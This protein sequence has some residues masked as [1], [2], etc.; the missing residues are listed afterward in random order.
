MTE[1]SMDVP[2]EKINMP[3]NAMNE[4][5]KESIKQHF[6]IDVDN[7][8]LS[9]IVDYAF[10]RIFTADEERSKVALIDFINSVLEF[11]ESEQIMELTVV[12]AN[13]P[14][15][16]LNQK[17]S[18]FDIR[19]KFNNGEQAIIE[20]QISGESDFKKRSQFIISKAYT[21]QPIAGLDYNALKKCYLICLTNFVL[22]KDKTEFVNDYMY[23]D[24]AGNNL[25]DDTTIMFIELPKIDRIL[26]K[27]VSEMTNLEMWTIFFRYVTDKSKRKMLN[28]IINR[29]DGIKMAT[30]VLNEISRDE[31][32]RAQYESELIYAMDVQSGMNRSRREGLEEGKLTERIEIAKKMLNRGVSVNII[33]EDTG[34]DEYVIKRLL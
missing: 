18:I 15:D 19:A 33:V 30:S 32:E 28:Q 34:L 11:K 3:W 25:S 17:K 1:V 16:V 20:M 2:E 26:D 24:K 10:K 22:F 6:G 12:N 21:S 4:A 7:E 23:R 31:Q 27:P 5:T 9:P 29:K 13:P 14:V 8:L